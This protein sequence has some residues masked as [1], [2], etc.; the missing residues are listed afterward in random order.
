MKKRKISIWIKICIIVLLFVG[1]FYGGCFYADMTMANQK[2][3]EQKEEKTETKKNEVVH[4]SLGHKVKL[5]KTLS[6]TVK[7]YDSYQLM[8]G[9]EYPVGITL[10]FANTSKKAQSLP[11]YAKLNLLINREQVSSVGIFDATA[12]R[13]GEMKNVEAKIPAKSKLTIVYLYNAKSAL[14]VS[15]DRVSV[16]YQYDHKKVIIRLQEGKTNK[17]GATSMSRSSNASVY[18][19]EDNYVP[20]NAYQQGDTPMNNDNGYNAP[21]NDINNGYQ[22]NNNIQNYGDNAY[23]NQG[24]VNLYGAQ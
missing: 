19:E 13:Q 10:E 17:S 2:T 22:Q 14:D 20:N 4:Y 16:E 1:A 3:S 24:N 18:Q 9:P 12:M 8:N 15:S 21:Q 23:N 5:S 6:M 11:S 7:G